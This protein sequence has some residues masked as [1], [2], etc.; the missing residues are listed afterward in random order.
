MFKGRDR[1]RPY[2]IWERLSV[3]VLIIVAISAVV[4]DHE[5][6]PEKNTSQT[7]PAA[8]NNSSTGAH[9]NAYLAP[10]QDSPPDNPAFKEVADASTDFPGDSLDQSLWG[11]YDSPGNQG[12]GLRRP[13]AISVGNNELTITGKGN[14]SGGM[15]ETHSQIYGRWVIRARMDKGTGYGPAILLWPDSEHWPEDGELD[16]VELPSGD[17]SEAV[18]TSHYGSTNEQLGQSAFGDYSQWHTYAVDWLPNEV[19]FYIDGIAR[20]TITDPAAIPTKPMHL[21]IQNDI[22]ACDSW[23]GCRNGTT[24]DEVAL[25]VSSVRVYSYNGQ[26]PNGS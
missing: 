10:I 22:G 4:I 12:V 15:A 6:R 1:G 24:P 23:I 14:V 13:S 26:Q 3:G 2:T 25:H 20:Y 19:I 9:Q 21:A 11:V 5:T 16:I 18:M 8:S 17:R 7:P